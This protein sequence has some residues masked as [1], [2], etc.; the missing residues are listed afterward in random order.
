M[1]GFH[2]DIVYKTW[3][4]FGELDLKEMTFRLND[5]DV[6]DGPKLFHL[7]PFENTFGNKKYNYSFVAMTYDDLVYQGTRM[8]LVL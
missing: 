6:T 8:K 1:N 5:D 7:V 3:D 2:D 4:N